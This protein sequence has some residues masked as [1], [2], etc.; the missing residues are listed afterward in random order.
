MT[1]LYLICVEN[2]TYKII[3]EKMGFYI[4]PQIRN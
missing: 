3:V 4:F 1:F 2:I